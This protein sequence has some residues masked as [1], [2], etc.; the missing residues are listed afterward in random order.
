MP[1]LSPKPPLTSRNDRPAISVL[2][3]TFNR[4]DLLALAFA[5]TQS[6][7]RA[8]GGAAYELVISDDASSAD[9][10]A[11]IADLGADRVLFGERNRGLGHNHN[12]GQSS[13]AFE[14]VL[15]LQDDWEFVGPPAAIG[16]AVSIMAHDPEIGVVNFLPPTLPIPR[17]ERSLPG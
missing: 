5:S 15:S 16:Q 3:L 1:S 7:L 6:A 9:H 17:E 4:S 14:F 11:V 10:T 8:W 13:C 2:F 12:K